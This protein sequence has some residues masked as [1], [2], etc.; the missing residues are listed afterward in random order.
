MFHE[1]A[2][3]IAAL[4]MRYFFLAIIACLL[5]LLILQSS[6][7]YRAIRRMKKS[8]RNISPGYLEVREPKELA[9]ECYVLRRENTIGKSKR[10]DIVVPLEDLSPTH[11][12]LYEKKDGLYVADCGAKSGILLNGE[13][14][15]KRREELLYEGDLLTMGTLTCFVHIYGEEDCDES[16]E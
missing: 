5:I 1:T 2:Y 15:G 11:A 4:G 8:I 14:I 3:D 13:R 10:S 7:E 9:G 12:L 6:R 16:M